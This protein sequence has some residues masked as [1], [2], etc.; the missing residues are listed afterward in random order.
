[1]LPPAATVPGHTPAGATTPAAPAAARLDRA[2]AEGG[3]VAVE[4]PSDHARA[5][6]R[7]EVAAVGAGRGVVPP[8]VH[9]IPG[10]PVDPFHE[11]APVAGIGE[12]D[13]L[14]GAHRPRC[15]DQ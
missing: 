6:D 8:H 14:A 1:M 2:G 4:D 9:L 12:G 11:E 13:D 7:A 3:V 5:A 15:G 10:D